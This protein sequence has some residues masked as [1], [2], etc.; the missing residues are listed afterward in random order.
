MKLHHVS[1]LQCKIY[2][3]SVIVL[4]L[5]KHCFHSHHQICFVRSMQKEGSV[6]FSLKQSVM[7]IDCHMP[8]EEASNVRLCMGTSHK[9]RGKEHLQVSEM[10]ISMFQLPLMSLLV[11]L[12]YLMLIWQVYSPFLVFC[13]LFFVI[14]NPPQLAINSYS[15]Q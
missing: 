14:I 13:W 5:F 1:C 7:L 12:I 6:L 11:G 8:W 3:V 9:V 15:S 4:S 2:F 10:E